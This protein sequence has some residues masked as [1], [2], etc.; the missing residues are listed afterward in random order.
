MTFEQF[1]YL[2]E[3]DQEMLLWTKGVEVASRTDGMNRYVLFQV[4]GFYMEVKY[5]VIFN[6]IKRIICFDS[7]D[8]LDQYLS[9]I[10]IVAAF[11][12]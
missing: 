7:T 3:V 11:N 8:L 1:K 2:N 9:E 12:R 5:S 4:E 6:L 10:D